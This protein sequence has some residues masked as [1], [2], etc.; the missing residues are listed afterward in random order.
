MAT[1]HY[2][3]TEGMVFLRVRNGRLC[4]PES[5]DELDFELEEG[6][7]EMKVEGNLIYFCK[8]KLP[9]S[10]QD[11]WHKDLVHRS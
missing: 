2:V 10:P 8:P 6:K 5:E 3:E 9:R 1:Y 7:K 11:W 4:F